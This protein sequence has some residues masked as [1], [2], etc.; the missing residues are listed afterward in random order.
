MYHYEEGVMIKEYT[1]DHIRNICIIG[2]GGTG[3]TTITENIL[4]FSGAI[5]KLGTIESGTTVSDFEDE[6][7]KHKISV[8]NSLTFTEFM[9]TKINII[10]T[11]GIPDFAGEVRAALRVSEGSVV[12]VD[13]VDG[14]QM[15]TRKIWHYA[16]EYKVPRIVFV[17]KMDKE[18]ADFFG[19]VEKIQNHFHTPIIPIEIPIGSGENFKGVI[20]LVL[21][22]ALYPKP[23]KTG[24]EMKDIPS[25]YMDQAKKYRASLAETIA[26]IDENLVDKVLEGQSLTD[27]EIARGVLE[28]TQKF[29]IIPVICG[30]ATKGIGIVTLLKMIVKFLPSPLF[31]GETIGYNP[32]NEDDLIARHPS[33]KEPFTAFV[34]KT[35]I[36]QYTGKTSYFRIRSGELKQDMEVL[37]SSNGTK[38]KLSHIYAIMG[39]KQI[40][41]TKLIAGDIG[42]VAKLE[43]VSTGDTLCDLKNPIKLPPLKLPKPVHSYSVISQ[44]KGDEEKVIAFLNKIASEDLT[45]KITYNKETKESIMSGM[46]EIQLKIIIERIEDKYHLPVKTSLPKIAYRETI[47]KKGS[48]RFKHKKQSG[49]HGQYGEVD[50]DIAPIDR[51]SGFEFE[52]NIVGGAIPKNFIPGVEK[53]VQEA[54]EEGILARF[55]VT[56][57]KVTLKDGTFH[58]VDSS[59]LSF[60]IAAWN[61]MKKALTEA[62]PVLLEPIMNV[63]IHADKD[64]VGNVLGDIQGRR[65]RILGVEGEGN[66]S[67]QTIKA[68]VPLSELLNFSTE[69]RSLTGDQATFEMD[70]SHYEP[71][72]GKLADKVITDRTEA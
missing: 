58:P 59:E 60:K 42:V 72:I 62:N 13:S 39:R 67:N 4:Y 6:E 38:E 26:D 35:R 12:I 14:I 56:D 23:D 17:N 30:S 24:V 8:H 28:C 29:K 16:D 63:E 52:D 45:F 18:Q 19:N 15:G 64:L 71:F 40:E 20:D 47:S 1:T 49:G 37:N 54:M 5:N 43:N 34:Y 41:V 31:I 48:A 44:K 22:K 27:D 50:I 3:K 10:D 70:L 65:G 36:D 9:D 69:I 51:G 55:P 25:E 66:T 57:I 68:Q 33:T 46:G 11:P 61:A 7:I 53:G 2:H 32:D 21:M